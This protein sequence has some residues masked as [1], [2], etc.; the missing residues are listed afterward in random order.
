MVTLNLQNW[1]ESLEDDLPAA[2]VKIK[3]LSTVDEL[4]SEH[5]VKSRETDEIEEKSL[6]K[7]DSGV[8]SLS[9]HDSTANREEQKGP[10]ETGSSQSSESDPLG[11]QKEKDSK[12]PKPRKSDHEVRMWYI[13]QILYTYIYYYILN[14][15]FYRYLYT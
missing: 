10:R 11:S 14:I 9:V 5:K 1:C 4:Q 2:D 8:I 7:E 6:N 12:V 13:L 3:Q 15:R